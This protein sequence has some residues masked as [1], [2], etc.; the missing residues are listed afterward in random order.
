MHLV[1]RF[2]Q[3][4]R[5]EDA[6]FEFSRGETIHTENSYKYTIEEFAELASAAGFRQQ[7]VW[8]D[9]SSLFSVQLL[10]TS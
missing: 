9:E 10:Q 4:V 8:T 1:S 2:Q 7:R 3:S 5:V 6:V